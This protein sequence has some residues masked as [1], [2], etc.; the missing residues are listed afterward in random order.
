MS[1]NS[2]ITAETRR[3]TNSEISSRIFRRLEE[4]KSDL[5]SFILDVINS[6]IEEKVIPSIEN[7]IGGQN[8]AKNTNF[9]S[10]GLHPEKVSQAAHDAQKDFPR[11]V[12]MSSNR[13]DRCRKNSV[14]SSQSDE[15]GYDSRGGKSSSVLWFFPKP[16]KS[17]L[18]PC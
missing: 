15:D 1:E 18:S 8:P 7:A 2:E 5:N 14:D 16:A 10:N 12:A 3:E 17:P 9:R 4:I 6:A 13:I 11:L